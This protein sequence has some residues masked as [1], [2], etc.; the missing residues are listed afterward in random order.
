MTGGLG[1][2]LQHVWRELIAVGAG[3]VEVHAEHRGG[4]RE[5]RRHVV[6]VAD[7][8]DRPAA[9]RAPALAQR[10]TVRQDLTRVLVVGQRVDDVKP[11]RAGGEFPSRRCEKVRTTTASTQRSR[12]RA[13]SATGSR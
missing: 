11:A 7:E 8:R 9:Q 13:M 6:A 5:R 12:L 1:R 10:Q 4:I 3:D 2:L